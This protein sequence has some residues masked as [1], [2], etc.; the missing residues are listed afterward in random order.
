VACGIF[1]AQISQCI[2][3]DDLIDAIQQF[4]VSRTLRTDGAPN[5]YQTVSQLK[6]IRIL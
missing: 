1:L 4:K 6:S 5:I 2:L 3:N